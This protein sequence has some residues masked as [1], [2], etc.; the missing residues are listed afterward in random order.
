MNLM[1]TKKEIFK[2]LLKEKGDKVLLDVKYMGISADDIIDSYHELGLDSPIK[3]VK[4]TWLKR[5]DNKAI[6]HGWGNGYVRVPDGHEFNG[7]EYM[8]IP[9]DVH[10]GLTFGRDIEEGD[11]LDFSKGFWVGFDTAHHSDTLQRWPVD[12]V[13]EETI[14]LFKQI[15]G[16]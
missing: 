4:N 16:L 10:G 3:L 6:N 1:K 14:D 9:V 8:D 7:M 12:R 2:N 15:Y 11:Y 5:Y 13:M